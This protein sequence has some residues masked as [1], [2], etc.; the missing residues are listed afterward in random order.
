MRTPLFFRVAGEG[1][2]KWSFVGLYFSEGLVSKKDFKKIY[3]PYS[4]FLAF[5]LTLHIRDGS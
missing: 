3:G 4:Y 1:S 5:L 2:V